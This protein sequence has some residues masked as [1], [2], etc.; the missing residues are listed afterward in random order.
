[1]EMEQWITVRILAG[2][3]EDFAT[4]RELV[5]A[6]LSALIL[7]Y[8]K[9][10]G[11]QDPRNSPDPPGSLAFVRLW[12][13]VS[14]PSPLPTFTCPPGKLLFASSSGP[15]GPLPISTRFSNCLL[16]ACC[17]LSPLPIGG[18]LEEAFLTHLSCSCTHSLCLESPLQPG[19]LVLCSSLSG[20]AHRFLNKCPIR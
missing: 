7:K 4:F 5:P 9:C 19:L 12:K 2:T 1:M 16:Q 20:L 8:S 15:S 11:L 18:H 6:S 3:A 10:Q 13:A 17:P 14:F